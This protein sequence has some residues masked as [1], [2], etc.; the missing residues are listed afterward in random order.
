M[1]FMHAVEL[2]LITGGTGTALGYYL[3][4]TFGAS[5]SADVKTLQSTVETAAADLKSEAAA[6]EK[7]L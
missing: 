2:A 1:G 3:G 5:V 6:V 7:K 4:K